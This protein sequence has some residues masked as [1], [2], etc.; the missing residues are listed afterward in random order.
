M[1]LIISVITMFLALIF[2]STGVWGEKIKGKLNIYFLIFFWIGFVFDTTGT[3]LMAAMAD[4]SFLSFH[5]ITGLLAII[6]MLIHAIWAT[7]VIA[8]KNEE[9]MKKFHKFSLFVWIIWL[10]P[11]ISGAI[12]NII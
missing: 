4:S 11:F 8:M 6:L 10:I 7:I 1:N 2:Y 12:F 9:M 5:G 3:S